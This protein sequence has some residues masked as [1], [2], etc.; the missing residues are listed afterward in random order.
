MNAYPKPAAEVIDPRLLR[1]VYGAFATG[2]TIVTVSG[3]TPHAMTAN[4]FTAVSLDP[5]LVLV[6]IDRNAVMHRAVL[7][8]GQFGVSVLASDQ[9][10]LAR[11]FAD[12]RRPLGATQF[13]YGAWHAGERTGAPLLDGAVAHLECALWQVYDGG[14]HSIVLGRVLSL[15]RHVEGDGLLFLGGKFRQLGGLTAEVTT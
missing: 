15:Q 9:A 5:A 12:R 8:A 11:Y 13:E 7:D 2:V 3:S 1:G 4:S 14:D 6:C 10:E